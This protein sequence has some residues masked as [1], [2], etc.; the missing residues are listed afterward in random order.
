MTRRWRVRAA[1]DRARRSRENLFLFTR[2][3]IFFASYCCLHRHVPVLLLPVKALSATWGLFFGN[4]NRRGRALWGDNNRR[5]RALWGDNNRRRQSF[6][7]RRQ[8]QGAPA[9]F[10]AW[11]AEAG[12]SSC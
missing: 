12:I 1:P 11:E 5:G 8:P 9:R 6:V 2:T 3:T 7:G 10:S 4:D